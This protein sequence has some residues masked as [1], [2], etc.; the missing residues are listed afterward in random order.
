MMRKRTKVEKGEQENEGISCVPLFS[1]SL[2]HSVMVIPPPHVS[3]SQDLSDLKYIFFPNLTLLQSSFPPVSVSL[4]FLLTGT[5][6]HICY[7]TQCFIYLQIHIHI[8]SF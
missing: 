5:I 4:S 6:F 1:T 3:L 7:N 8:F 2:Q